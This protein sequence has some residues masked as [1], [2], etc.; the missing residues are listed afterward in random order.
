MEIVPIDNLKKCRI[1]LDDESKGE[2]IAPCACDGTTKYVHS[3]CLNRWRFNDINIFSRTNCEICKKPYL[4]KR[5]YKM[6]TCL[7]IDLYEIGVP[8]P[9]FRYILYLISISLSVI[10]I[11]ILD[12]VTDH[13]SLKML[14]DNRH[15]LNIIKNKDICM[16]YYFSLTI[17]PMNPAPAHKM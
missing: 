11:Y 16:L 10:I 8:I 4:I 12:E 9:C 1:C 17:F 7:F 5:Q 2:L 14:S 6:E 3:K 15:L 13:F